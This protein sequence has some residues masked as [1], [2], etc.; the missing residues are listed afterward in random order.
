MIQGTKIFRVT[1]SNGEI[2]N[3]KVCDYKD[4]DISQITTADKD[5]C[6]KKAVAKVKFDKL[7]MDLQKGLDYMEDF[8]NTRENGSYKNVPSSLSFT[9][10]YTQPDGLFVEVKQ[11]DADYVESGDNVEK[12]RDG[13]VIF[14]G[15][16]A[17]EKIIKDSLKGEYK[18]MTEY[19]DCTKVSTKAGQEL[20][21]W[22][23]DYLD[24]TSSNPT[25]EIKE[26]LP[27]KA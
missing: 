20:K 5:A 8:D 13:R 23:I 27:Y 2:D 11:D 17:L 14:K 18:I 21:G 10:S 25:I 1:V 15:A 19:Y 22:V 16:K 4:F 9:L 12:L 7:C 6:I 26:L 24:I 3:Y